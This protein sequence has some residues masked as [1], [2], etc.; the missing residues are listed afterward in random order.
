VQ[1]RWTAETATALLAA[2]GDSQAQFARRVGVD[3]TTVRRWAAGERAPTREYVLTALDGISAGLSPAQS[4]AFLSGLNATQRA[5][6]ADLG[7][8]SSR[9]CTHCGS[10]GSVNGTGDDMHRR[11]A[12][13]LI[14]GGGLAAGLA[15]TLG[16]DRVTTT[17]VDAGL[18]ASYE[19][20]MKTL[21]TAY[22][23]GDPR[24]MLPAAAGF[25]GN[26]FPLLDRTV[27][28]DLA[29]R[30]AAVT[31]DAH[32]MAGSLAFQAGNRPE[33]RR[34]VALAAH[35]ADGTGDPILRARAWALVAQHVY[36]PR[37]GGSGTA[38]QTIAM[39]GRTKALAR[40]ADAYTRVWVA[41][42]LATEA[43]ELGDVKLCLAT[44]EAAERMLEGAAGHGGGFFSPAARY[45]PL[46]LWL[47]GVSGRVA[48]LA[49]DL[50]EAERLLGE[51]L[52]GAV[53]PGQRRR[54]LA[55][56]ARV[57]L[58]NDEPEGASKALIEAVDSARETGYGSKVEL[59]HYVR[60]RMPVEWNSLDCVVEL[61]EQLALAR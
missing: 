29:A 16:W 56:L 51:E 8:G 41:L 36:S 52:A 40:H 60:G 59:A 11:T 2:R 57:R 25:A 46:S 20:A 12:L 13:E 45:G 9:R 28:A 54:V 47:R 27:S 49:G 15:G 55:D 43:A 3:V 31:V 17:S 37:A 32:A 38:R 23:G 34:H 21:A 24:A 18:V 58:E 1:S 22:I 39:L 6:F 14:L 26:L 44:V 30:L 61:D 10:C 35:V 53:S 19:H 5:H 48:G 50:E 33:A 4:Q 7:S 42:S